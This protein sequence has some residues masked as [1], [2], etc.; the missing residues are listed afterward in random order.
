[1]MI[2]PPGHKEIGNL[3]KVFISKSYKD[4][5]A[6]F[7]DPSLFEDFENKIVDSVLAWLKPNI[8]D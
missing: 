7:S 8:R 3:T 4:Y 5:I 6:A 1:M 2:S